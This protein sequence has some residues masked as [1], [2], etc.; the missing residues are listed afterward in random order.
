M[1]E[2]AAFA[3]TAQRGDEARCVQVAAVLHVLEDWLSSKGVVAPDGRQVVFRDGR[4]A[5][6]ERGSIRTKLGNLY[7]AH[8]IEPTLGGSF[9]TWIRIAE[10]DEKVFVYVTLAAASEALT[11]L[12][13]DVHCPRLIRNLLATDT[14]WFLDSSRLTGRPVNYLGEMGGDALVKTVWDQKRELPVVAISDDYGAVLHPGIVEALAADLAGLA[15]VARLDSNASWRLT[16]RKGKAWSCYSGA[17]R[18]Y[19]PH[20]ADGAAPTEHPLW[21]PRRLLAGVADTETAAGRLRSQLRRRILGQSAFGISEPA[22]FS[23]I[24]RAGRQE[25]LTALQAQATADEDY[26]ALADQYFDELTRA[27][28]NADKQEEEIRSLRAQ[29]SSLQVALQWKESANDVEP[30]PEVPPA[31]VE[32]AVLTA[33]ERYPETVVF[34]NDVNRGVKTVAPDAGPPDKILQYLR[35]LHDLTIARRDGS[36]GTTVVKWLEERGVAASLE[37]ETITHSTGA[38]N[39]R[40]W[41]DGNGTDRFFE[42]HLKPADVTSPDRCVRIYLDYD[43]DTRKT[44]V[45]WVGAH[46]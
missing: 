18:L 11:P 43:P 30:D 29:V 38:R 22:Q 6:L 44:I 23:A 21:T 33:M 36:L 39:A 17:I 8:L 14:E 25:T 32:E 12:Y 4:V 27:L 31:T 1:R 10:T 41:D 37:S 42:L 13:I 45:G 3:L 16:A 5:S 2:L 20:L 7:S 26:R 28:E 35:V 34:G 24:R 46:P 19:W 15:V 9:R 40:T